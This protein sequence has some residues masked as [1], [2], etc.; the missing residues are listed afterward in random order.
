MSCSYPE[1]ACPPAACTTPWL[2]TRQACPARCAGCGDGV[3]VLS[4]LFILGFRPGPCRA[5]AGRFLKLLLGREGSVLFRVAAWA[6]SCWPAAGQRVG[7]PTLRLGRGR[8]EAG[9]LQSDGSRRAAWSSSGRGPQSSC[10]GGRATLT[11]SPRRGCWWRLACGASSLPQGWVSPPV[12]GVS[13]GT[14]PDTTCD[15]KCKERAC[16]RVV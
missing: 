1:E 15:A 14:K 7:A 9:R 10:S 3:G 2:T 6:G 5:Y 13:S 16:Q 12:S 11:E 8:A 4:G